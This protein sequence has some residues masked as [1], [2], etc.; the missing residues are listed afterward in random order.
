MSSERNDRQSDGDAIDGQTPNHSSSSP[1]S[2]SASPSTPQAA[3][4]HHSI[5]QCPICGGGLCG[6]RV[7]SGDDPT[8]ASARKGFVMCDECEAVWL[9]PDIA[10]EHIYVDPVDPICP[11]CQGGLWSTSHW[12]HHDEIELIGWTHALNRSL[13]VSP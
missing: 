2:Q 13:D 1:D 5:A 4:P 10:S 9:E 8:D 7:C 6:V 12:A 11:I 3:G